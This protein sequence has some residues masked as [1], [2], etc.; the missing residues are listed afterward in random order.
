MSYIEYA[1]LVNE[2]GQDE[3]KQLL[4]R[5]RDN[6]QDKDVMEENIAFAEAMINDYLRSS[7]R[8]PSPLPNVPRSLIGIAC[9]ITRYRLYDNE[10]TELV[11]ERYEQALM[12]LKDIARGLIV[13]AIDDPQVKLTAYST[14][15]PVFTKLVW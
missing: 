10:P 12:Y 14:P 1:D 9:D 7:G 4:D 6:R 5:N 3:V 8:Y 15:L 11:K 13:L 2:F